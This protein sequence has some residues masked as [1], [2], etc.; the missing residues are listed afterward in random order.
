[1]WTM[2][3]AQARRA[4][5]QR[6]LT[7]LEI[8]AKA[9]REFTEDQ[10]LSRAAVL[11]YMTILNL[12]PVLALAMAALAWITP[13][14]HIEARVRD[15]LSAHLLPGS[16]EVATEYLLEFTHRLSTV[17]I[18]GGVAFLGTAVYLFHVI[19]RTFNEIWQVRAR[20]SFPEKFVTYW[21]LI[22]LTPVIVSLSIY[23]TNRT[24][25]LP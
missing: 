11:A 7:F 6:R 3:R 4:T 2:T 23:L 16:I 8:L 17:S 14:E 20:R 1:M 10:F 15:I 21:G 5:P 13:R 18:L 12:V 22:T 19:E 25:V 9:G 24:L